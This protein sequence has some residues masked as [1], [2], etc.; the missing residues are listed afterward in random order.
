L[1]LLEA[2]GDHQGLAAV[3]LSL[4]GGVYNGRCQYAKME[5]AAE[6]QRHHALLAGVPPSHH[7]PLSIAL[8]H[9]PRP[10]D[11]ALRSLDDLIGDDPGPFLDLTRAVLLAM[12]G[13]SEALALARTTDKQTRE[14]GFPTTP[15]IAEV[16]ALVGN[17]EA[18]AE[19]MGVFCDWLAQRGR[20]SP[21]A[22][23]AAWRGRL[24][25]ELGRYEEAERL[26]LETRE[27]GDLDDPLTQAYW[28]Q[29]AALVYASRCE[30][31]EAE[32]LALEA[33][34]YTEQWI[35][36]GSGRR[37]VGPWRRLRA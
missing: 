16:E 2:A 27:L 28:R 21:L 19:R 29:V 1:P 8:V 18:A 10:A 32:R 36:H 20:N 17:L 22:Y 3:W 24:L 13:R 4:A 23:Y 15:E 35:P 30:P 9:G 34:A 31:A 7:G 11:E 26:G 37:P 5:Y 12:T 33:V 14:L 25:C 6:Q